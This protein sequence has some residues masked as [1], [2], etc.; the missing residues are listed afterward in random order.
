MLFLGDRAVSRVSG[1]NPLDKSRS[2][3]VG[4]GR[5]EVGRCM[6]NGRRDVGDGCAAELEVPAVGRRLV[7]VSWG[8]VS[9]S[10][11]GSRLE[12]ENRGIRSQIP[13]DG[14]D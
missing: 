6:M 4:V 3:G 12:R 7:V 5:R 1:D 2:G 9:G 8:A 10:P 11:V 14:L 13:A